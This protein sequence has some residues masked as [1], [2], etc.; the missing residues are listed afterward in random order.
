MNKWSYRREGESEWRLL[1]KSETGQQESYQPIGFGQDANELFVLKPHNGR[2]ALWAEH[3]GKDR[4]SDL[5]FAHNRDIIG[6]H[7]FND[8]SRWI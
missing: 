1:H 4:E 5:V 2:L 7:V 6:K 8:N 3:L